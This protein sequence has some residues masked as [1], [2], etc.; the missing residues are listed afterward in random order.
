VS[1]ENVAKLDR[2][3]SHV[4]D[5]LI[6]ERQPEKIKELAD[7]VQALT[8]SKWQF[9]QDPTRS[10]IAANAVGPFPIDGPAPKDPP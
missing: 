10:L 3:V 4:L 1:D 7:A 5:R 6:G 9:M 8:Y 2:A